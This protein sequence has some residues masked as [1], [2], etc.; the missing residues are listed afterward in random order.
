[1][2]RH[3]FAASAQHIYF[4]PLPRSDREQIATFSQVTSH[5]G[6]SYVFGLN[7]RISVDAF[8]A[9]NQARFINHTPSEEANVAVSSMSL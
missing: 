1:M 8:P 7:K 3:S 9:G 5:V 6:R 2:S 4:L